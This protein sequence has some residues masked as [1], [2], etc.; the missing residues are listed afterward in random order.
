[1]ICDLKLQLASGLSPVC[2][3]SA[4]LVSLVVSGTWAEAALLTRR[5]TD[6]PFPITWCPCETRG[7]SS[8]GLERPVSF[9]MPAG[10]TQV[11]LVFELAVSLEG[12]SAGMY[13][14]NVAL[15]TGEGSGSFGVTPGGP[16]GAEYSLCYD[17]MQ[18][19]PALLISPGRPHFFVDDLSSLDSAWTF[20]GC[21]SFRSSGGAPDNTETGT[22]TN[23]G[24]ILLSG[25][26][27][28]SSL[29]SARRRV[30]GLT[31]GASYQ[32]TYWWSM[33]GNVPGRISVTVETPPAEAGSMGAWLEASACALGEV[34]PVQALAWTDWNGDGRLDLAYG[35]SASYDALYDPKQ[36]PANAANEVLLG[37]GAGSFTSAPRPM[38]PGTTEFLGGL[39]VADCDNDGDPDLLQTGQ[40]EI[41]CPIDNLSDFSVVT[42]LGG[43]LYDWSQSSANSWSGSWADFD[44]DGRL[45]FLVA[46]RNNLLGR[47]SSPRQ[48]DY[49]TPPS[50]DFATG[51]GQGFVSCSD[52]DG[53]GLPDVTLVRDSRVQAFLNLGSLNFADGVVLDGAVALPTKPVDIAW[54]DCDN[55][56]DLDLYVIAGDC[57]VGNRLL[58]NEGG[59][60]MTDVTPP[61][62]AC[63]CTGGDAHW[64]DIDLDG[65]IDLLL[66]VSRGN[67]GPLLFHNDGSFHFTNITPAGWSSLGSTHAAAVGDVDDDGDLDV[68]FAPEGDDDAYTAPFEPLRLL[69]NAQATNHHWLQIRLQGTLSNRD[70][71]G[72]RV[73]AHAGD[74]T[75]LREITAG[76]GAR[77]QDDRRVHFGLGATQQV[78][79]VV[80][81][82]PSGIVQSFAAV[83]ADRVLQLV[84]GA[85]FVPSPSSV[86]IYGSDL[87]ALS[88]GAI[89]PA[90]GS[91]GQDGWVTEL[92]SGAAEGTV[93]DDGATHRRIL[94]VLA[95]ASN[96]P[97]LQTIVRRQ[98]PV[99]NLAAVRNLTLRF[100]FRC[101][102]SDLQ[103]SNTYTA[104]LAAQGGPHPGYSMIGVRLASGN[105]V[106][107]S[108]A[109]VNLALDHFNPTAQN[110]E[111]VPLTVGQSLAWDVWHSACVTIDPALDRYVMVTVDGRSQ[112]LDA[113]QPP[114]SCENGNC[115]RGQLVEKLQVEAIPTE[116]LAPYGRSDDELDVDNILLTA[117]GQRVADSPARDFRPSRLRVWATPNPVRGEM[118]IRF[119][120]PEPGPVQVAIFDVFGRKVATAVSATQLG[121]G[122]HHISF[123]TSPLPNGIYMCQLLAGEARATSKVLLV[124]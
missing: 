34:R 116:W 104:D 60:G 101:R 81:R 38:P 26:A 73:W 55:D 48:Y 56:G 120:L 105:G 6:R 9:T 80:V 41:G 11:D 33:A 13:I 28:S 63:L 4:A 95:P 44:R 40:C 12:A 94:R 79:S 87:N 8:N 85:P 69:L 30:T 29:S 109:G 47:Q 91:P 67:A 35:T 77:G 5:G 21:A 10:A 88:V 20:S 1:M 83:S 96:P 123:E 23:A 14:D 98:L 82:W 15:T 114:R 117:D 108:Q 51:R 92:V 84:E 75:Q 58:R 65:R 49:V 112:A 76:N 25:D 52:I 115:L 37:N 113:Y 86:V 3:L 22:V 24:C 53:D 78:D 122:E 66:S 121:A 59:L 31:P 42:N 74:Q 43:G 70:A 71:I 32:L 45:D 7:T 99:T 57:L 50:L 17:P 111:P 61:E 102:T 93:L 68:A 89:A 103:A 39:S 46:A 97:G 16:V 19:A 36:R 72:A 18:S 106:P 90:P 62:L 100:D 118:T 2:L 107:K 54:G 119:A 27:L 110:N 124:R 64:A